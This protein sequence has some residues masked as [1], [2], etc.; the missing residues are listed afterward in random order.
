M[1]IAAH[2]SKRKERRL[3]EESWSKNVTA[4]VLNVK[5]LSTNKK[6]I[7]RSEN[8]RF[9]EQSWPKYV[10]E[11]NLGANNPPQRDVLLFLKR[12]SLNEKK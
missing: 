11:L 2:W 8:E 7:R 5:K 9:A 6:K 3:C 4:L 12:I 10:T 1:K